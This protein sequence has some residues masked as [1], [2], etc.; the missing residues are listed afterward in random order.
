MGPAVRSPTSEIGHARHQKKPA[1]VAE[2]S[3]GG[4]TAP[5]VLAMAADPGISRAGAAQRA[6]ARVIYT[7]RSQSGESDRRR[8]AFV[9]RV[10]R[11]TSER[12]LGGVRQCGYFNGRNGVQ[13]GCRRQTKQ[14]AWRDAESRWR[15]SGS[16]EPKSNTD[17]TSKLKQSLSPPPPPPPHI[18]PVDRRR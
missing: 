6:D 4:R 11:N 12:E 17:K 9:V 8:S 1:N 3:M 13:D 18:N 16:Q 7:L 14:S 5:S 10:Q 2:S 15:K